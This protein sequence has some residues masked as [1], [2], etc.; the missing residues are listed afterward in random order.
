MK[1]YILIKIM[2]AIKIFKINKNMIYDIRKNLNLQLSSNIML[3]IFP[4]FDPSL[5]RSEF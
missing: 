4:Y 5:N 3:Y 1:K 2:K